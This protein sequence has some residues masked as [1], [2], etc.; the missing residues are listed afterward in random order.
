MRKSNKIVMCI[1]FRKKE[2]GYEFLLLKRLA[3]RGS[4][5]QPAGG[6]VEATDSSELEAAYRELHEETGIPKEN[7]IRA[8]EKFHSFKFDKHYLTGKPIP[9]ITVTVYGFEVRQDVE[10]HFSNNQEKPEHE[11]F[12]WVSF[13][14]ALELLKWENNKDSFRKLKELL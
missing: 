9:V 5:W 2:D 13:D 10:I 3:A 4:F 1:P 14:Q 11:G 12:I 7:V 8:I 6:R